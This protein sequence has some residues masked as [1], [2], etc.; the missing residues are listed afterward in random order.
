MLGVQDEDQFLTSQER[1]SIVRHLLF[2]IKIIQNK[3][4]NGI[5]F[6]VN[7][8]LSNL[9]N[10]Q[11]EIKIFVVFLV[12]RGLEK[13]LIQQVLPLHNKEVLNHLRQT[14]VWPKTFFKPQ[15]IGK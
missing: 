1:Q 8:S 3:E 6:K 4:I 2:S 11:F 7:Q 15:P 10:L 9:E 14:W 12:Q 5:K 13:Q